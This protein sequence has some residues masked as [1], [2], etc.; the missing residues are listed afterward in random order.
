MDKDYLGQEVQ[1]K[2]SSTFDGQSWT[3]IGSLTMR[4]SFNLFVWESGTFSVKV[5]EDNLAK[6]VQKVS[7]R[8]AAFMSDIP[9]DFFKLET[10]IELLTN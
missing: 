3:S 2:L 8:V 4:R 6:A 7:E 10:S 5:T 9:E 1:T